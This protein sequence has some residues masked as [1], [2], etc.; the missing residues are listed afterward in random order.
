MKVSQRACGASH[1]TTKVASAILADL[2]CAEADAQLERIRKG[3][4][5]GLV[6][7]EMPDP[8]SYDDADAFARAYQSYHLLRKF[9]DFDLGINRDDVAIEAFHS[10]EVSCARI[11]SYGGYLPYTFDSD[12]VK[13]DKTLEAIIEVARRKIRMLLGPFSWDDVAQHWRFSGGASTRL[14]R[15]SGDLFYKIQ[16][17][18]HVTRSAALLAICAIWHNESWR[19]SCQE[20]YGNDPCEWVEVVPGSRYTTVPKTAKTNRGICVEPEMN[21]F[22]QLGIG[23]IIRRKLKR[24]RIDLDDQTINQNLARIGSA[25]GSLATID[26]K[27]ASDSIAL[28]L[29]E[30][31]MPRD[32][33]DALTL[34]R[35]EHTLINGVL[36]RL[37]KISSM[38]NGYTFE[39]ESLLFWAI[40]SSVIEVEGCSDTRLGV[41]GDD[42]VVHNSVSERLIGVLSNFGF[43]TNIE[44]TFVRG[45]FRESC[46]KHYFYGSDVSPFSITKQVDGLNRLF[47]HW[48]QC[49][50][51][52]V[53]LDKACS[54]ILKI[55]PRRYRSYSVPH[56][57]SP[58]SGLKRPFDTAHPSW[59]RKH[60]LWWYPCLKPRRQRHRPS[61]QFAVLAWLL[62]RGNASEM[63]EYFL[64]KGDVKYCRSIGRSSQWDALG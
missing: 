20:R 9:P 5:H 34:I 54:V 18:P 49:K 57:E 58:E 47:L 44:K 22:F 6:H 21:M 38:G 11:N 19:K 56:F 55:I 17:K 4:W 39:L 29:V 63:A 36:H 59:S 48:N 27:S 62:R 32:W 23:A 10:S 40:S 35:C 50:G 52:W 61:G 31:L 45:P 28:S 3:D 7:A 46:G 43:E 14:R 15:K 41:Y 33:Y 24:V 25:T 42:I 26:L 2:R 16:G 1:V 64:E 37:E 12:E 51:W 60:Q 30:T 8:N 53:P 13:L